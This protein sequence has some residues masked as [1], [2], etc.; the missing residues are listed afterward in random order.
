MI[1][2]SLDKIAIVNEPS[3]T[4]LDNTANPPAGVSVP[5]DVKVADEVFAQMLGSKTQ[6]G[7]VRSVFS[8]I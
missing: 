8:V 5:T 1:A 6:A 4:F 3:I 2:A 7:I